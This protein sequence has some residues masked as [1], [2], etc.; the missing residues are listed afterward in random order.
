MKSLVSR[1]KP[2]S[3]F[4]HLVHIGLVAL[5][6]ALVFILVRIDIEEFALAL[7]LL[8]KWRM[9]AVRPRHWPANVRANAVDLIVGISFL[10]FMTHS[11]SMSFQLL[12]TL[13]YGAWLLALKPRSDLLSVSLQAFIAQ[14]V[15]TV[16]LFLGWGD[17]PLIVLVI[18]AWMICYSAARH[19]FI[20]F[21]E[22]YTSLYSHF[23]GYF[24]AALVWL[25][26]HW[27]LFYGVI[28][29]PTLLL[30]VI[31]YGLATLYYLDQKDKLSL[32]MRRQFMF[33]M[34][35]IV[36]VVLLFSSWSGKS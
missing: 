7:I 14:F 12:W 29:Q 15:G 18:G 36:T 3:G 4:A 13:M 26:G 25:L 8:S 6:P 23:W 5:L 11:G 1:I 31:G 33:I 28:A 21:E 22:P 27:L 24:A 10:T 35:A 2:R 17:A 32:L 34:I 19:F 30:T 20:S 9:L 16:A